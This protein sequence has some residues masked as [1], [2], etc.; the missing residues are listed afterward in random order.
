MTSN[1]TVGSG[2]ENTIPDDVQHKLVSPGLLPWTALNLAE[3]YVADARYAMNSAGRFG[4]KVVNAC[5]ITRGVR[6]DM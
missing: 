4:Q 6:P 1:Y 5:K 2:R 3:A